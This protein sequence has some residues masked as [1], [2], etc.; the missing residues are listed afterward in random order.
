MKS[1]REQLRDYLRRSRRT[2]RD[3]ARELGLAEPTV[4]RLLSAATRPS[5]TLAARIETVT[6]IPI[7][8]WAGPKVTGR[9]PAAPQMDQSKTVA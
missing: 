2:Q 9:P 8:A 5:I 7:R 3:F 1:G 6:G 4:S